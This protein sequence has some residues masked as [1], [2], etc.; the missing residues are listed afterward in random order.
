[1]CT[2]LTFCSLTIRLRNVGHDSEVQQTTRRVRS[3]VPSTHSTS[4]IYSSFHQ[5]GSPPPLCSASCHP[6]SHAQR[7]L[8]LFG[9]IVRSDSDED[10]SRALNAGI[11]YPP[12]EW[13]RPRGRPRQTWLRTV[14]SDLKQQNLG[15]WSARHRAYDW[16][17][18][19]EIVETTT[20]LQGHAT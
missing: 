13:R 12:K 20:L 2:I 5:P 6:D 4:P 14:E 7:L 3:E 17:Q 18:W 1:M 9:H 19:R 11:D 15:L 16:E 8:R 10:H